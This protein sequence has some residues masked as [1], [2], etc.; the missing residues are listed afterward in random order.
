[1]KR[2]LA[3]II[4]FILTVLLPALASCTVSRSAGVPTYTVEDGRIE[5][6]G[7]PVYYIGTNL[8]YASE[9]AVTDRDRLA[10]EL[11]T[12]KAIGIDN[13]R[14]LATDE[15][16]EGLDIVFDELRS[17]SMSA[18]LYLNNAWEWSEQGYSSY[19][20]EAGAGAQPHPAKDGY[21]AYMAAMAAFAVNQ[22]AVKLF[23]EHVVRIVSRYK[24][25]AAI[26]SWQICNEPR[27]FTRAADDAFI[28]YIQS[29]ARL[30]KSIDPRHLVSTGSEGSA[31][32]EADIDFFERV[33]DCPDIDYLTIHIW[34]YNW[35]WVEES[36][37]ANG[38]DKA[39]ARTQTYI[40]EHLVKA[41]RLG[42]PVVIE[43]FGYPRDGFDYRNSA[44]TA[45]RDAYYE[46][47]FGRVLQS[48]KEAGLLAGCNFWSWSGYA[49]QTHRLWQEGDDLC[50]DPSQEAQG[51]NSVYI[52]D[53]STISVIRRYTEDLTRCISLFSDP[54]TWLSLGDGP[55]ILPIGAACQSDTTFTVKLALVRD[56][57]LQ[58][59]V[60]DTVLCKSAVLSVADG[61]S[62]CSLD[63]GRLEPGFYQASLSAE[64]EARPSFNIGVNPEQIESP[65][66][67]PQD[68]RQFWQT[69]LS[70]LAEVDPEVTLSLV[71]EHSDSI[72]LNYRVEMKSL[73]GAKT[74]GI[75]TI[76]VKE[77]KYPVY[78]EYMGYGAD[79]FYHSPEEMPEAIQY[80][81]SVRDQG[82]FEA[83]QSKWA[84]R[85]LGS[86]EKYY[87]RGAYCD[88]VRAVDF[89][90]G[91][92]KADTKR[93]FAMGES[94]GG[95][96]SWVAASLDSRIR[97]AA[98]AVPFLGDFR[99]YSQI[100]WWPVHEMLEEAASQ[101]I[102]S[103]D[104]LRMLRYFDVKNFT[105]D[106][107]CPVLMAFGLQDGT[108]PPH[109]NFAA[110]NQVKSEK[111]WY[112]VP[113]CSHAMWLEPSWADRRSAFFCKFL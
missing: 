79:P 20:Q 77:G 27:A 58:S 111:Q 50:G 90:A 93:I 6:D 2:K 92:P 107:S 37:I 7:R 57:S 52:G 5:R 60:H 102:D 65:Q 108:C 80:L 41:H 13:L 30:I 28:E 21:T 8:W 96:F 29:T 67:R 36:E 23:K 75:L 54:S 49:K 39:I 110:F 68:F 99:H 113:T 38:V 89:V 61:I 56:L 34:P 22:E 17:R 40:D 33:H 32:C 4:P 70:E 43:E 24:D 46:A 25:E 86:K 76:P 19:L 69:T 104:V 63:L 64:G 94:Q 31:G 97:A 16:F 81:V 9:L 10:R 83:G 95:A 35:K 98:P 103:S 14:I 74:G 53:N 84:D 88:V 45:G 12:L 1:M 71:R 101:G 87:Y 73:G 26:F 11:D 106:I 18:V 42:K 59:E 44:T 91:L 51:L 47:V 105:S 3:S 85:G 112:C 62:E 78:I 82:L 100:V 72:R 55:F 109:T 15:N 48:A 66:D